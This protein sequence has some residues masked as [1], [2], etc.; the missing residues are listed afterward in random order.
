[1][2]RL[3]HQQR[4][5][6]DCPHAFHLHTTAVLLRKIQ[7]PHRAPLHKIIPCRRHHVHVLFDPPQAADTEHTSAAIT[8]SSPEDVVRAFYTAVNAKNIDNALQYIADDILYEDFTYPDPKVGKG[9]VQAFL[10]DV[11]ALV[12]DGLDYIV[13]DITSGDDSKVGVVWHVELD[14]KPFPNARG[15]SFY[16]INSQGKICYARDIVESPIKAGDVALQAIGTLAPLVKQFGSNPTIP[17]ASVGLWGFY[18]G[19]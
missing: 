10:Q 2:H 15:C 11:C 19:M 16:K 8:S 18:A 17:W 5:L 12:P 4:A 14:G 6:H 13:D 7:T 3:T 1:M 9:A